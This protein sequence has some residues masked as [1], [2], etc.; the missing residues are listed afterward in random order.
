MQERGVRRI[1]ADLERL[2]PVAIDVALECKRVT[3]RR[4]EAVD[5]RK[6]RRLPLTEK[7]PEDAA[8]LHHG[9]SALPD[10]FAQLRVAGLRRRLQA[11][12][13]GIEQPAVEGAA[14]A[15]VFETPEREVGA[16]MRAMAFDQAVAVL[17]VAKQHEVLAKQ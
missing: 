5:L 14:Q 9:I 2:Q 1:D 8:F 13:R 11:L 7:C 12:T 4:H 16:A 3:V 17:L 15:A 6:C 10:A